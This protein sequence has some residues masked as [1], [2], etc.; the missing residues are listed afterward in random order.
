MEDSQ[1]VLIVVVSLTVSI[2]F[3]ESARSASCFCSR[4]PA[5]LSRHL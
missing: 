1:Q 4:Y 2:H 5:R 3:L